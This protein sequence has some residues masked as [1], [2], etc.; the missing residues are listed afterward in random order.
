MYDMNQNTLFHGH[1]HTTYIYCIEW[2]G[3]SG[4]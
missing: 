3:T 4:H 1:F 2:S